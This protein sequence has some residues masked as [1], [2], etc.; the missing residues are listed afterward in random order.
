[1][2]R[3][4]PPDLAH[5]GHDLRLDPRAAVP[6]VPRHVSPDPEQAGDL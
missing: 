1:M 5:R 2:Q 4:P 3:L 6:V